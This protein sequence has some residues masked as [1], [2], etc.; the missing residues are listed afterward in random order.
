M[1]GGVH[2]QILQEEH[3]SENAVRAKFAERPFYELG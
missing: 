1:L 2:E 3:T